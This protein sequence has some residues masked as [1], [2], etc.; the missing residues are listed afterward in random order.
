MDGGGGMQGQ[1]GRGSYN[2]NNPYMPTELE[3]AEDF[4]RNFRDDSDDMPYSVQLQEIANRER[5]VLEIDLVR[6][7]LLLY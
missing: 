3:K 2:N 7:Y 1:R 4:L 5:K 6:R